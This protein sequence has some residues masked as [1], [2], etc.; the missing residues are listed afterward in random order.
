MCCEDRLKDRKRA[1]Q[2]HF[3][4]HHGLQILYIDRLCHPLCRRLLCSEAGRRLA[5]RRAARDPDGAWHGVGVVDGAVFGLLGLIVAFTFSG[6][7]SRFDARRNLIV[8][9]VNAIGTAWLRLDLL[10]ADAQQNV[11][12]NFR[13][14]LDA[15]IRVYEKFPDI[16]A[17]SQEVE[18]ANRLQTAIWTDAV[19]AAAGSQ[20][21]TMLLLPALNETFDVATTRTLSAMMHPPSIVYTMLFC[22]ALASAMLAG[23]GMAKT[24]YRNWLHIVGYAAVTAGAY[25]V[26]VDIEHPRLGVIQVESLDSALRELR[27]SMN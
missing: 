2:L 15:R 21:A 5:Q 13:S 12:N 17:V 1:V 7:S 10:P 9:E 27:A 25:F 24:R 14:Y 23:Y 16:A 19:A 11:R 6:A 3:N 18:A 22:L 26:I 4:R 8:Q 20:S